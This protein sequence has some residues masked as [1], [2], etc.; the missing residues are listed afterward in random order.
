MEMF[1]F[2]GIFKL[3][4]QNEEFNAEKKRKGRERTQYFQRSAED[5]CKLSGVT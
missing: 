2:A 5:H 1:L 4:F 3:C